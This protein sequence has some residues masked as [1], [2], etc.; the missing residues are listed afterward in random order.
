M[1]IIINT[2]I[3]K[4]AFAL[5]TPPTKNLGESGFN[6]DTKNFPKQ[7][8]N[9]KWSNT[10]DFNLV[11]IIIA[12]YVYCLKS[13]E[14]ALQKI[15]MKARMTSK[16]SPFEA[17]ER[18]DGATVAKNLTEH[19]GD[20]KIQK[21]ILN[22][23]DKK[24]D[25]NDEFDI[26]K[27]INEYNNITCEQVFDNGLFKRAK[28]ITKWKINQSEVVRYIHL[29]TDPIQKQ[30]TANLK[31]EKE[32]LKNMATKEINLMAKK[33]K[34]VL[35][36]SNKKSKIIIKLKAELKAS[37]ENSNKLKK[38]FENTI[39]ELNEKLN[40]KNNELKNINELRNTDVA[41]LNSRLQQAIK[42]FEDLASKEIK[43]STT[44]NRAKQVFKNVLNDIN[45]LPAAKSKSFGTVIKKIKEK[46]E[47]ILK[48]TELSS[49]LKKI[50]DSYDLSEMGSTT[51]KKIIN[52]YT[53]CTSI[54]APQEEPKKNTAKYLEELKT[55]A[56]NIKNYA[57]S[58]ETNPENLK[59][60]KESTDKI[61]NAISN[62][63]FY[64][65]EEKAAR[66][67]NY[68]YRNIL[69]LEKDKKILKN[70]PQNTVEHTP[71]P[72]F[73]PYYYKTNNEEDTIEYLKK[74]GGVLIE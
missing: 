41:E 59:S 42:A 35:Q 12:L 26:S 36:K 65:T 11:L 38:D 40:I 66:F 48:N 55:F 44:E 73:N 8:R 49:S 17:L 32:E 57:E 3:F 52:L 29:L 70:A 27:N 67:G 69:C 2:K 9:Y 34:N 5:A 50:C 37:K 68:N 63:K 39:N 23:K 58:N 62:I 21:L 19:F 54:P 74:H 33:A 16:N 15:G 13:K 1:D 60:F 71:N 24:P 6:G 18:G 31:K 30:H 47:R 45:N 10:R 51:L 22:L 4:S 64:I 14:Q 72:I 7:F 53:S 28:K 25:P 56:G 43:A 46:S 20:K 61:A